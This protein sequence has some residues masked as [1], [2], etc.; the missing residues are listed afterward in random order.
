M[1]IVEG[2]MLATGDTVAEAVEFSFH[3]LNDP[4]K[5]ANPRLL[6]QHGKPSSLPHRHLRPTDR[7]LAR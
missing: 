4:R 1:G 2:E 7:S 3:R 5:L 6:R